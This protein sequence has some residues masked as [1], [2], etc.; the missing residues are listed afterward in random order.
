[1]MQLPCR[2]PRTLI[3]SAIVM[4]ALVLA[5]CATNPVSKKSDFVLMSEKDEL[6]LGQQAAAQIEKQLPLLKKSDSLVRYV[7]RVGQRVARGS[8][9]PELFY[10]F[11]V[12]DNDDINAFALPGGYIYINRGLLTH[13]NSEAEL[14]AILGHEI[15]HV[16]ARHAVKQYTKAQSYNIGMAIASIFLPMPPGS[17]QL[18]NLLATAVISGYGREAE[19]QA[20]E[21]SLKYIGRAGYDVRATINILETLQRLSAIAREE[22][23]QAGEKVQEYHGAFASHPETRKRITGAVATAASMQANGGETGHAAMLAALDGYPYG[24]SPEQGAVVGNRFLHPGLG[25]QFALTDRWQ[26]TNT[27]QAV[28]ARVRKEKIYFMLT[29]SELQKRQSASDVLSGMFPRRRLSPISTGERNG[30]AYAH[31]IVDVSA[32]HVSKARVHATVLLNGPRAYIMSM[33]SQRRDF[34][35][36]HAEFDRIAASFRHYDVARD[37][38]VPRISL[39]KWKPGDDWQSL[40]KKSHNI[41]GHLTAEKLAALNGMGLNQ[42][43]M[44]GSIIKTVR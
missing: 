6:A 38:D 37:G 39:H 44:P 5:A 26:I 2:Q 28:Q 25:I 27:P 4:A 12:V 17:D 30:F 42:R 32:P 20:D 8:D 33:W 18:A 34:E 36:N 1:M 22:K 29:T 41:L 16:T 31:A 11:H 3:F 10:R 15:G 19:L 21:L 14:A 7:D 13:M 9:R 40:A 24:D 43:P 23:A 35:A